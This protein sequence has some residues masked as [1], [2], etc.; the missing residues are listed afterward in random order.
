VQVLEFLGLLSM[1]LA[2]GHEDPVTL[3]DPGGQD[4]LQL[5]GFNEPFF[6]LVDLVCLR[7]E[8][9]GPFGFALLRERFCFRRF[10]IPLAFAEF[11]VAVKTRNLPRM[12]D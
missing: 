4:R 7:L 6:L 9:G 11:K 12:L 5:P 1:R 10:P 3:F 8:P 2:L